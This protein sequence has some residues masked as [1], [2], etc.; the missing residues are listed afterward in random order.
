[1]LNLNQMFPFLNTSPVQS[2]GSVN[3][4]LSQRQKSPVMTK[5][6]KESGLK[7]GDKGGRIGSSTTQKRRL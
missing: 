7:H 2:L 5:R 3:E 4:V 1:M 6:R